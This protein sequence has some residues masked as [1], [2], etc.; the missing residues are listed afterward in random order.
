MERLSHRDML[1]PATPLWVWEG[2]CGGSIFVFYV[3]TPPVMVMGLRM[4]CMEGSPIGIRYPHP[5]PVGVGR[6]L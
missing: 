6:G 3:Y 1:P 5:L 2:G 4:M